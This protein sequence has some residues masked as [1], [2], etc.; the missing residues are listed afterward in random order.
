MPTFYQNTSILKKKKTHYCQ[1]HILWKKRPVISKTRCSCHFFS[2]FS[3]ITPCCEA[4]IGSKNVNS[5]KITLYFWSKKSI[6]CPSFSIF[7]QKKNNCCRA[8]ICQK[9][10]HS[11]NNTLLSCPFFVKNTSILTKNTLLLY[12]FFQIFNEKPTAFMPYFVKKTPILSKL[13]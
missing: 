13:P 3:W 2:N 6:G 7:R 8:H 12:I 5:L 11:L 10:V 4:H 9:I 1:A